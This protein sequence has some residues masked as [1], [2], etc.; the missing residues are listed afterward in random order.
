M[1]A[2]SA[3]VALKKLK[4]SATAAAIRS[5]TSTSVIAVIRE[6]KMMKKSDILTECPKGHARLKEAMGDSVCRFL[7]LAGGTEALFLLL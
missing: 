6:V 5:R 2:S 7:A 4:R 3:Q 1:A